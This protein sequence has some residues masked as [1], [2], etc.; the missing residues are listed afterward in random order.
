MITDAP[1]IIV[2]HVDTVIPQ[3][4]RLTTYTPA[5]VSAV[6]PAFK[7]SLS[8]IVVR[9]FLDSGVRKGNKFFLLLRVI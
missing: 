7:I 3:L 4:L 5:M 6:R 8:G 2:K 9:C 1:D